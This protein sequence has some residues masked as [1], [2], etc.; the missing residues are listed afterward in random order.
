MTFLSYRIKAVTEM[1]MNYDNG[2]F[3]EE[4]MTYKCVVII[5]P[6]ISST[7]KLLKVTHIWMETQRE[8]RVCQP[9]VSLV[10]S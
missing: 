5:K 9:A 10:H 2:G 7:L 1:D 3:D 6:A 8:D 4:M